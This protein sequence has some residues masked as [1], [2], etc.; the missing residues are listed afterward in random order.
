MDSPED[1]AEA[2]ARQWLAKMVKAGH[3]SEQA[4]LCGDEVQIKPNI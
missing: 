2:N 3:P 1:S 4:I